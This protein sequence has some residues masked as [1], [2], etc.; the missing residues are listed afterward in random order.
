MLSTGAPARPLSAVNG[1]TARSTGPILVRVKLEMAAPESE[2]QYEA[3]K[4]ENAAVSDTRQ[5][6]PRW[7]PRDLTGL[8]LAA[9]GPPLRPVV[10]VVSFPFLGSFSSE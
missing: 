6:W 7:K 5:R 2:T 8:F 1:L 10:A 3:G 9:L 4:G